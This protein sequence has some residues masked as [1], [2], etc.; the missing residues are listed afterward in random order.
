MLEDIIGVNTGGPGGRRS[1]EPGHS[2][3]KYEEFL[4]FVRWAA[5]FEAFILFNIFC[6]RLI[7]YDPEKRAS[8]SE[9]LDHPYI[10]SSSDD[11]PYKPPPPQPSTVNALPIVDTASSTAK[12]VDRD[13]REN[14][15]GSHKIR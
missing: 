12:D 10:L 1:G 6:R 3:A 13:R 5:P 9:L 4:D 7:V 8:A 2:Q 14:D 11:T 15:T